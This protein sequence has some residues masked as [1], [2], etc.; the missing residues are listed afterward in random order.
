MTSEQESMDNFGF[1]A[2]CGVPFNE[3]R[4]VVINGGISGTLCA[5]CS[6]VLEHE[7]LAQ[8]RTLIDVYENPVLVINDKRRIIAAN[9]AAV[10]TLGKEMD[11]IVGSLA[12]DSINCENA[13]LPGGCGH[14]KNCGP[15][16]INNSVL[17]TLSGHVEVTGAPAYRVLVSDDGTGHV[18]HTFSV[19]TQR[20]GARV[21]VQIA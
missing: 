9:L 6:H 4:A 12:G 17:T 2:T 13:R 18:E 14:S 10:Q 3:Q 15:C 19:S 16:V 20:V 1:C 11:R 8:L 5:R 7:D 21:L